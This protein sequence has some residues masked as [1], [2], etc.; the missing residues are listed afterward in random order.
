MQRTGDLEGNLSRLKLNLRSICFPGHFND[1]GIRLGLPTSILPILNFVLTKASRIVASEISVHGFE[2][3][4]KTDARF[5]QTAFKLFREHFHLR[6]GLTIA[7]FLQEGYAERK[8]CLL[9][10]VIE[11]CKA[12]HA[13]GRRKV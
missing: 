9:L 10:S 1:A 2:L 12:C 7:Q 4:G 8:I 6:S 11:R 5:V 13:E 3:T